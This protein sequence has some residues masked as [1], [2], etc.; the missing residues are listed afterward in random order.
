[1][2]AIYNNN[3]Q[4]PVHTDDMQ[5]II[6]AV[7]SWLLRW[8]I[9]L[10]FGV[11]ILMIGLS[12]FIRYPDVI[13]TQLK[14]DS[15][16]SPKAIVAKVPGKLIKL[17]VPENA[18]VI[19]GQSIAYLE[20][21]AN[22]EKVL[23]LLFNLKQLQ[24][25]ILQNKPLNISL[26]NEDNN[27]QLGEIQTAYQTFFT[28]YL[29]YLSSINNGFLL[30]KES[31]LQN[32]LQYLS[33]Q[34]QQLGVQKTIEQRDYALAEQEYL[35]NKKLR[36]EKVE[37]DAEF[38]KAESSYLA[39]K[40]PIVQTESSI[41]NGK[42]SYSSK[43]REIQE[44]ANEVQEEK[45]RFLQALNSL[46]SLADDWKSKYIL[47]APEAGKLTYAGIVQENQQVNINQELFY[48]NPGNER[49]F[50]EMVIPQNSLGKVKEGQ[51]VL[52]KLKGYPFEE[53]GMIKGIIASIS[54]V[55]YKDSIFT[56]RVDF[57]MINSSD[58]KKPVH[59][60]QGMAADAEI[61]TQDATIF[62]RISR[63]LLLLKNN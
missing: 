38:R 8:G 6:T 4:Q 52:V 9:L 46:I 27:L 21:T 5:D 7:P 36:D 24:L 13:K 26:I 16:N 57:K 29:T 40:S 49:F 34:Q 31:S 63:S 43:Q 17:L 42:D 30:K 23:S 20:S 50:G 25:Q 61:I 59:L 37:T 60:K 3:N 54:D 33:Q 41:I 10:F 45:G 14:I 35:M 15:P 11:F 51:K 1:M 56:A 47:I 32:D 12:A 48:V 28:E 44:V 18:Q 55:P 62:Q 19:N 22:H 39:K 2:P 58:M 53:F